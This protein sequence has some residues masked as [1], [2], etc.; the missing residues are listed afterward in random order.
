VLPYLTKLPPNFYPSDLS[1]PTNWVYIDELKKFFF[2]GVHTLVY[3]HAN[4]F[5]NTRGIMSED[6][7]SKLQS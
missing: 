5:A 1:R 6:Y 4:F 7:S 2:I 3:G